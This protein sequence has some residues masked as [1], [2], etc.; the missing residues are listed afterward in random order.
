M[1]ISDVGYRHGKAPDVSAVPGVFYLG[2]S[3]PVHACNMKVQ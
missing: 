3:E 2:P 1:I